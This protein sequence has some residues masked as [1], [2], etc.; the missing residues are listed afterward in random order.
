MHILVVGNPIDGFMFEGLFVKKED[1]AAHGER[2]YADTEWWVAPLVV[3]V[4]SAEPRTAIRVVEDECTCGHRWDQHQQNVHG[5]FVCTQCN[6]RNMSPPLDF[7]KSS[8]SV[9]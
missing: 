2:Y 4:D 6:C 3:S 9:F 8:D 5:V 1:A 7:P